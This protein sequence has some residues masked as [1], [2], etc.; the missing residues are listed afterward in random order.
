[1]MGPEIEAT[2]RFAYENPTLRNH[3]NKMAAKDRRRIAR[4]AKAN[5][6]KTPADLGEELPPFMIPARY[7]LLFKFLQQH[8]NSTRLHRKP[9][10]FDA[11]QAFAK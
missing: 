9:I 11:K 7:K 10:P 1:M 3:K 6:N 2:R 5:E 8:K 4:A